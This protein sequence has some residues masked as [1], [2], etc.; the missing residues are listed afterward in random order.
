LAD[1]LALLYSLAATNERRLSIDVQAT[2][3]AASA[4]LG[5]YLARLGQRALNQ[6]VDETNDA[7]MDL[8]RRIYRAVRD[9]V[10]GDAYGETT[11]IRLEH[12]PGS[13]TKQEVLLGGWW[14]SGWAGRVRLWSYPHKASRYSGLW[15]PGK[16]SAD[17]W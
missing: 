13:H 7:G 10:K 16:T 12:D 9:A 15:R 17:A 8:I 14:L 2:A 1:A 5:A 4:L 3:S 6:A 11:L